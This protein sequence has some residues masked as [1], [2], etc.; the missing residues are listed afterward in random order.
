MMPQ[1]DGNKLCSRLKENSITSTIPFIMLTAKDTLDAR[2]EGLNSG[3]DAY[4]SK[5]VSIQL[6]LS[7][8]QNLLTQQKRIK[9]H[10]SSNYLSTAID[11]TMQMKDKDF[12]DQL[13]LV[14]ESNIANIDLDVDFI[15]KELS[16][17]RTKLYQ[18]VKDLTGKPIMELVR[19]IRL[20]K[21][22]QIMVE[23]DISIQEIITKIGIQSQSYFTSSFKKEF[24]KTPTQFLKELKGNPADTNS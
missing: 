2:I 19:S 23:E 12:Y 8:I 14:I 13:I 21:A 18:R 4:L 5:P 9:E 16:L 1:M 11:D 7:T 6:L 10:L 20:R 24:G 15:S 17:S 3:A 22:T